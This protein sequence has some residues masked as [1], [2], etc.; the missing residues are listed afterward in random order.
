MATSEKR[1]PRQFLADAR[2]ILNGSVDRPVKEEPWRAAAR[3]A[4]QEMLGRCLSVPDAR[5]FDGVPPEYQVAFTLA[6]LAA[7]EADGEPSRCAHIVREPD[8]PGHGVVDLERHAVHCGCAQARSA[9][10]EEDRCDV[11]G[12]PSR[13]FVEFVVPLEQYT[14]VGNACVSCEQWLNAIGRQRPRP[15]VQTPPHPAANRAARRRH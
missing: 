7:L 10:A 15:A 12:S 13:T 3:A 11:C 5:S 2:E 6:L 14:F 8:Y 4:Q 1:H 9:A